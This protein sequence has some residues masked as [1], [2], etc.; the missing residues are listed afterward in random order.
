MLQK[1]VGKYEGRRIV[2]ENGTLFCI[3]RDR[4]RVALEPIGPDLFAV[5][6]VADFRYR[7][8]AQRGK[9]TALERVN[10][11]GSIQPYKRLD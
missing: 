1:A 9:V 5:E 7:L 10:R 2:L 8:A 11:D 4:L 3:W 6:G